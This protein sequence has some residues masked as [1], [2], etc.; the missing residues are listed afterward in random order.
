MM[1][2]PVVTA[3]RELAH[4]LGTIADS[5]EWYLFGSVNRDEPAPLDI[6]VLILCTNDVQADA[7]RLAIDE[8]S[9]SLR[10]DL[11]LMTFAEALQVDAVWLQHAHKIHPNIKQPL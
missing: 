6:D 7:L 2:A 10:I 1:R 9:L 4:R 8:D 11:S 3:L 5:S